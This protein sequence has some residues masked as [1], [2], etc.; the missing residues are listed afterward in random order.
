MAPLFSLNISE[1]YCQLILAHE[2][3]V[4]EKK[5]CIHEGQKVHFLARTED[6]VVHISEGPF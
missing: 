2:I 4:C 6:D 1:L 3:L 5:G